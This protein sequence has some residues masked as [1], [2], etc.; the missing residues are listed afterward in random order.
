MQTWETTLKSGADWHARLQGSRARQQVA[1]FPRQRPDLELH[2]AEFRIYHRLLP[3][4]GKV[5]AVFRDQLQRVLL[6]D[7]KL[8]SNVTRA[9]P[10]QT[11]D[12]LAYQPT[13]HSV[14]L[15]ALYTFPLSLLYH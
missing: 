5:D 2:S 10:P 14:L 12:Q 7:W 6:V 4:C 3:L 9:K 8:C 13:A 11:A 15:M 1:D